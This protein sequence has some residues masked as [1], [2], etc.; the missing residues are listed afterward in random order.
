VVEGAL[1][2]LREQGYLDD[3]AYARALVS[4]RSRGRG[5]RAIRAELAARGVDRESA[6]EAL[7]ELERGVEVRAAAR[8][9]SRSAARLAVPA[10]AGPPPALAGRLVRRGYSEEVVRQAWDLVAGL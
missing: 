8:L 1:E 4:R 2:R 9:L 6:A 3:L 5:A 7:R 10:G